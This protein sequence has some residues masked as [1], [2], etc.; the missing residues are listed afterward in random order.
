MGGCG[1]ALMG[2]RHG[3]GNAAKECRGAKVSRYW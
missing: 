1:G 3:P 2:A